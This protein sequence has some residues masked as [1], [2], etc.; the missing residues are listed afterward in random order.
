MSQEMIFTAIEPRVLVR[1]I[2][3]KVAANLLEKKEP[4]TQK[5]SSN[6]L[7][8]YIPKTEVRNRLASS[9]T[10]W[11]YENEGRL[12]VYGVGGKRYYK[13]TDLENLFTEIKQKKSPE[14]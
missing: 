12:K 5:E 10:L 3:E 1:E 4:E 7:D 8:D 9:S 13:K 6:P 14:I 2:A 11:K